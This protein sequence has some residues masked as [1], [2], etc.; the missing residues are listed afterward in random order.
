MADTVTAAQKRRIT[1]A[2]KSLKLI[3]DVVDQH[4]GLLAGNPPQIPEADFAIQAV[5]YAQIL[6]ELRAL[7]ISAGG[8]PAE[9][10]GMA[11]FS[12]ETLGTLLETLR[13]FVPARVLD[14]ISGDGGPMGQLIAA[15]AAEDEQ[16]AG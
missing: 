7:A 10:D 8:Q 4:T 11:E 15:V 13:A 1:A 6:A 12:R 2:R 9:D 14:A 16:A 5:K 3:K